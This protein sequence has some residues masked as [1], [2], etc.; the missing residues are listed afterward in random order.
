MRGWSCITSYPLRG[1]TYL[2]YDNVNPAMVNSMMLR[3]S[4]LAFERVYS[5]HGSPQWRSQR[6]GGHG[7]RVPPLTAKKKCQKEG[8]NQENREKRK[9]REEMEKNREGSFT[10][11]LLTDT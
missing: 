6:G 1:L 10:L 5:H 7:S 3:S 11:P 9:N 8:G 4:M 2:A